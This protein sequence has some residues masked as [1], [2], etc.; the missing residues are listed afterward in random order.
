M[1]AS[2]VQELPG[3]RSRRR[4]SGA[5]RRARVGVGVGVGCHGEGKGAGVVATGVNYFSGNKIT[6]SQTASAARKT[7]FL[8]SLS[9]SLRFHPLSFV[10]QELKP[11]AGQMP[12][13]RAAP[14]EFA[15]RFLPLLLPF[16]AHR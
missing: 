7:N 12:F 16:L 10:H 3:R 4:S 13:L 15:P 6:P 8:K 2:Q 11:L 9:L 14:M 5:P 1:P